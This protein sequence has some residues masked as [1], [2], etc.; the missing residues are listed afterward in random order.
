[1]EYN[2]DMLSEARYRKYQKQEKENP[3]VKICRMIN[4]YHSID[5]LNGTE[6]E[7]KDAKRRYKR[8]IL[9]E[10]DNNPSFREEVRM[11]LND[12][13]L[14]ESKRDSFI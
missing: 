6:K 3:R 5:Q 7:K 1:M 9:S 4:Q 12:K 14:W 11:Y 8:E 10:C 13:R 2:R